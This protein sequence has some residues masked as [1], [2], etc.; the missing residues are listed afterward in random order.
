MSLRVKAQQ[1]GS[2]LSGM[3]IPNL[4]AFMAWGIITAVAIA[5][6][7]HTLKEFI[8][9]MLNYLLPLLIAFAAGKAVHDYRGGV[10]A[11]VATM[12]AILGADVTMFIGAMILGPLSAWVLKQ[13]DKMVDGKIPTGFELLVNN[14]SVGI[15]GAILA[16]LGYIGIA[17]L[18]TVLTNILSTGVEVLVKNNLLPLTAIF[19]EPAKILFLN[20]AIGQGIL[21]PLGSTQ[22][23]EYGKSI[24]YLLESNPGPGLGILLAYMI[25][26]KGNSKGSAYGAG[27][28]H[29]FGG[30][31]EIY[32]PY[33]LMNPLLV[34][35]LIL[36]GVT[37]TFLF[38]IFKV[39]LI[40]VASPGSILA[41]LM[42]SAGGD[43]LKIL[44]A[45]LASAAVTFLV[46]V[47]IVKRAKNSDSQLKEAATKME[48]LKGKKS[49]ISSVF[50][51]TEVKTVDYSTTSKIA[52]ACDAGLGS[53]AMGANILQK[54]IK[55]AGIDDISVFHI[56]ISN[57]PV[58]ADIIVTHQSLVERV[59]EKQPNAFVISITDYLNDPE[60]GS[61]VGK[62]A[63]SRK[64]TG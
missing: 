7:S 5:L 6:D 29:F 60:Y 14:F 32:F 21:S 57:L 45:V 51:A 27:V 61:L 19:I 13:F 62:L 34:L 8:V 55:K 50:A 59:A 63:D 17:P 15:F 35:P 25:A 43:H 58:E 46:A 44:I 40:G 26:G 10:I 30:I 2:K 52:Y 47:P 22:L 53:S 39:G 4:G 3:V 64:K 56:S 37:G 28:I 18:V 31:H 38:S 9:P 1:F 16:W 36:G 23:T 24:L 41:I 12:G 54:K 11:T 33:V 48:Q 42:M 49:S 20:N